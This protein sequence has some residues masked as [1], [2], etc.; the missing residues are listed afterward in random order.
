MPGSVLVSEEYATHG[1]MNTHKYWVTDCSE[2]VYMLVT[3]EYD[4]RRRLPRGSQG[5]RARESQVSPRACK[6][7]WE[8]KLVRWALLSK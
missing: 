5:G 6:Q 1:Y 8:V 2:H 4:A 3:E 7:T